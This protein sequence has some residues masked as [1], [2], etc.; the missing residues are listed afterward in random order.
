MFE[1]KKILILGMARSGFEAAKVLIKKGNTVILNDGKPEEKMN[2]EQVA[3]LRELGV[4]LVFGLHPD[5]LLDNSIDYLVKN[6]GVPIKHKYVLR[7]RELGIEVINEVELAY[8]LLPQDVKLI[9]IT[10]TN[11]KTT[12]T[13]LT[14]NILKEAFPDRVHLAG[15]IGYPLCSILDSLRENDIIVMEVSAQ[16]GENIINFKPHIGLMTNLFPAHLE[17]FGEYSYYK[18]VKSKMFYNQAEDDI[19]IVNINNSDVMSS[20]GDIKSQVKYFSSKN[21][22][23]GIYLKD[24]FI[25]YYGEKVISINDIKIKGIHNIENCMGAI[26]I[27][28]EFDV[29]NE[30]IVS[31]ISKFSG[32][33]H[34]LEY[35][36]TVAGR[37]F[38]NDTEATNIKCTQIALSSFKEPILLILGGLERNQVLEDLT[39]FMGNVK[40]VLAIGQCRERVKQYTEGLG[41]KTFCYEYMRDG[42][43]ELYDYSDEG[44]V[45]LLSPATAS[46][47]QYK[48][49][50]ERGAEFKKYVKEL[51]DED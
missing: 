42:F 30:I 22:V 26:A 13:T 21:E 7:A 47:D 2:K 17:F 49:C 1:N 41:I 9:G 39:P 5:D 34:R 11:G 15:N 35:V 28:K 50:E 43:K 31:V 51:K 18:N 16:Q 40:A 27:A 10:G 12:T 48:E 14:Y 25:Y 29:S 19:A 45:I 24:D 44:D 8:R 36:D 23:N 37:N 38:Y 33:E 32:V 6:P 3:E 20:L 4:T 46:W